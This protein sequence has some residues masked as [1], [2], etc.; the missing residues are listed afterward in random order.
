MKKL[1]FLLL[2]MVN[3]FAV[4]AQ[5]KFE[6]GINALPV[7]AGSFELITEY[8]LNKKTVLSSKFGYALERGIRY[9]QKID[10]GID[11]KTN[12]GYFGKIGV[13]YY[14]TKEGYLL[15]NLIYSNYNSS[16]EIRDSSGNVQTQTSQGAI[17]GIGLTPGYKVTYG[18]FS[19]SVGVQVGLAQA[20]KAYIGDQGHNYQPGLGAIGHLYFQGLINLMFK[21]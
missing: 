7:T 15:G 21:I 11:N 19:V 10:D 4:Q 17:W 3:F 16:G 1:F 8:A 14:L 18:S 12:S 20:R 9:I 6:I 13:K 5:S 2:F